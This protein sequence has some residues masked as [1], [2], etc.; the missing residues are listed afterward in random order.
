M[1]AVESSESAEL[2]ADHRDRD[3]SLGA[4]V[5]GF[6]IP[7]Q[8]AVAHEPA[9]FNQIQDGVNE[10][11]AIL[12]WTTAVGGFG[13]HGL[14]IS[15]LGIGQVGVV[16]GDFH[17][18]KSATAKDGPPKTQFKSSVFAV[19]TQNVCGPNPVPHFSDTL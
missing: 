1:Q 5:G 7:P 12:G 11:A 6:V 14:E 18:L 16:V 19:F 8:T 10:A 2:E 17:R 4:G 15:P 13:Q 9:T 3:P